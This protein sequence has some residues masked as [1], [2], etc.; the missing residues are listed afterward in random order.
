MKG[1]SGQSHRLSVYLKISCEAT[2]YKFLSFILH[3]LYFI[4]HSS[5]LKKFIVIQALL[6]VLLLVNVSHAVLPG[7]GTSTD[8]YRIELLSHFQQFSDY[9]NADLYW[10]ANVYVELNCDIQLNDQMFYRAIIGGE[11]VVYQSTPDFQGVGYS[12]HFNGNGHTISNFIL[13]DLYGSESYLAVFGVVNSGAEVSNLKVDSVMLKPQENTNYMAAIAAKNHGTV[14][15]CRAAL[16]T[17]E[18][19]FTYYIGGIVGYN[20]GTVSRCSVQGEFKFSS[21]H[22]VG[23]ICGMNESVIELSASDLIVT[24]HTNVGG[25]CGTCYNGSISDCYS[26]LLISGN[27]NIGGIA[28]QNVS[29]TIS[30]CYSASFISA[31]YNPGEIAGMDYGSEIDCYYL[32]IVE[33]EASNDAAPLTQQQMCLAES[34]V[35]WDFSDSDGSPAVWAIQSNEYPHLKWQIEYV[36]VPPLSGLTISQAE[37]EIANASLIV[38]DIVYQPSR[39]VPE[40]AVIGSEPSAG[41]YVSAD[42]A[43]TLFAS[44]GMPYSGGDGSAESPFLLANPSDIVFLSNSPEDFYSSFKLVDNI[45]MADYTYQK[46][47]IGGI[48]GNFEGNFDGAEYE[49][50]DITIDTLNYGDGTTYDNDYLGF[51][52]LVGDMAVIKNLTVSGRIITG[53]QNN[54]IGGL[55]GL[56]CGYIS[57]CASNFTVIGNSQVGGFCGMNSGSAEIIRCYSTQCVSGK[58]YVGGFCGQNSGSIRK[59]FSTADVSALYQGSY[60]GGF[61][62]IVDENA[63]V[64]NC[65]CTGDISCN[66]N[67]SYVGGFCGQRLAGNVSN[68]YCSGKLNLS[69]GCENLAY[70]GLNTEYTAD[71]YYL[72]YNSEYA[73]FS[74]AHP[75]TKSQMLVSESFTTLD[76]SGIW[77]MSLGNYPQ[78]RTYNSADINHDSIVDLLDLAVIAGQW[79][80]N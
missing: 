46:A 22:Y 31:E 38:A 73:L 11:D 47:I 43:V 23:G 30:R 35:N 39:T 37:A 34:F 19:Y 27:S 61:C 58:T 25:I 56:N 26:L 79:L 70:F 55:C 7:S 29:S 9:S 21:S 64:S 42:S 54:V 65:Y 4:I 5:S 18:T 78:I 67:C 80:S 74:M 57:N 45:S 41:C 50:S 77:I 36:V 52:G 62:G 53:G 17:N 13:W 76:F 2:P 15:N 49:I 24:G 12:G 72:T 14:N 20:Y 40:G 16:N 68:C 8:P 66:S 75:L 51:F 59:C 71:C 69:P 48:P 1:T 44:S 63:T 33:Q 32:D 10:S 28:G 60:A 3:P 6:F